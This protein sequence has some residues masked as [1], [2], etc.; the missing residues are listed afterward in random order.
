MSSSTF[1]F[2]RLPAEIRNQIFS[3]TFEH[4]EPVFQ[5]QYHFSR[6]CNH[7]NLS[8]RTVFAMSPD[9]DSRIV[10]RDLTFDGCSMRFRQPHVGFF[11]LRQVNRQ[12]YHET[13]GFI[14]L[15]PIHLRVHKLELNELSISWFLEQLDTAWIRNYLVDLTVDVHPIC[16]HFS[17]SK[18][19]I[20]RNWYSACSSM[21][22]YLM[23]IFWKGLG[24][25]KKEKLCGGD[26]GATIQPLA[27]L[28]A[29]FPVLKRVR[30]DVV[31]VCPF[32]YSGAVVGDQEALGAL[33][34]R[35][36]GLYFQPNDLG[37]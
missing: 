33:R 6:G 16:K 37:F 5:Y 20:A 29:T 8:S 13:S 2:L 22:E 24:K 19:S 26:R 31:Q 7:R 25:T 15:P 27:E 14:K 9:N 23:G 21:V 17:K 36:V 32:Q 3:Y 12:I 1:P 18:N 35:K 34:N 11:A 30:I 10:I 4:R 28:L